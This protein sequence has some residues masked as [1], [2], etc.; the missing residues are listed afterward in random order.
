MNK[1][2]KAKIKN[3]KELLCNYVQKVSENVRIEDGSQVIEKILINVYFREGISTKELAKNNLLPTPVVAAIKREFIKL[4]LLVQDRGVRLTIKGRCF[5]ENDL[6]F[7]G[8]NKEL[9]IR[10]ISEPWKEHE[11]IIELKEE[12]NEIFI[13]RP[14][15]DVTIDQSKCTVDTS[16]KRALLALKNS[17]LIGKKILCVGDDDLVSI[18]IGFLL[19]KLFSNIQYSRTIILVMDID[20]RVLSYIEALSEKEN[21]PIKC[22]HIDFRKP[23]SNKFRGIFDCFFTDPPYTLQGMNLFISRGVEALKREN[24]IPI[25]LSYANKSPDFEFDMQKCFLNM[26]LTVSEVFTTFN[27]YE[28]AGIIGSTGQMIILKTTSRT[29]S[30]INSSYEGMIYTGEFKITVRY[31][32]CKECNK[33]IE[34]GNSKKVKTIEE[35]KEKG[36]SNCNGK[37]FKIIEKVKN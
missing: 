12:L 24:G 18:A 3:N 16:I 27:S 6:G 5:I 31:Y 20:Q 10:L 21:L 36:C 13:N 28:S 2:N 22:E 37:I 17:V 33:I 23:I 8:V 11:E 14:Q 1:K 7:K 4:G 29:K 32:K 30:S 25:F 15:A 9:Y 26:G 19:K 35:L 34:V